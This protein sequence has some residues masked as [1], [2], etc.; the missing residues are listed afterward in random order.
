V[1]HVPDT[2]LRKSGSAGNRTRDIWMNNICKDFENAVK[3]GEIFQ[4]VETFS[5]LPLDDFA[6]WFVRRHILGYNEIK[7]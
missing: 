3:A 2:L 7:N 4:G 6:K 5:V 1:D